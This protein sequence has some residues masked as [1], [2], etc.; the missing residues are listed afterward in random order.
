[1]DRDGRGL[2]PVNVNFGDFFNSEARGTPLG[3]L[4]FNDAKMT[5]ILTCPVQTSKVYG[6]ILMRENKIRNNC[7]LLVVIYPL[8]LKNWGIVKF[9]I[10]CT[11]C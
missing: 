8:C 9:G 1:M 4:I 6:P 7:K 3:V 5:K 11:H 10:F 2:I